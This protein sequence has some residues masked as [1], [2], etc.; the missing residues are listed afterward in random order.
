VS[1]RGPS[2]Q[3]G[4]K[5]VGWAHVLY[6]RE[7]FVNAPESDFRAFFI[8]EEP[9]L[10]RLNAG[11]GPLVTKYVWKNEFLVTTSKYRLGEE[12]KGSVILTDP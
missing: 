9:A 10:L 12:Q 11:N 6:L 7:R 8:D 5:L 4:V 1:S 3:I 2:G